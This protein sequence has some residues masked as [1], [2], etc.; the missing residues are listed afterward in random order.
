MNDMRSPDNTPG[1]TTLARLVHREELRF[2][3]EQRDR[4]MA[5]HTADLPADVTAR[6]REELA[7]LLHTATMAHNVCGIDELGMASR[8]IRRMAVQGGLPDLARAADHVLD[9]IVQEDSAALGATVARLH[10]LG[11]LALSMMER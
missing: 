6:T 5:Y 4:H 8:R 10:R 7:G 9:C 3:A 2:D 1:G 11:L